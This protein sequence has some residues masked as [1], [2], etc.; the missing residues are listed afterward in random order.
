MKDYNEDET[1]T[2]YIW[3]NYRELMSNFEREVDLVAIVRQHAQKANPQLHQAL[4]DHQGRCGDPAIESALEAGFR[5]FYQ[6]VRDRL[7]DEHSDQIVINRCPSCD[8]IVRTPR[9]RV[10]VWCGHTWIE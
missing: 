3:H 2:R 4:L 9:A 8:R 6:R 10:C 1:L 5:A 7:L